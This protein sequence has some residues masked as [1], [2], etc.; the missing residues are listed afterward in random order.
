MAG[1]HRSHP[2]SDSGASRRR[3]LAHACQ[4]ITTSCMLK[5]AM[6]SRMGIKKRPPTS[7]KQWVTC[8]SPWVPSPDWVAFFITSLWGEP[9]MCTPSGNT[10]RF[11]PLSL[12]KL[13]TASAPEPTACSTRYMKP[14]CLGGSRTAQSSKS[15]AP[16]SNKSAALL[17]GLF[18]F[19][20]SMSNGLDT[21]TLSSSA[22]AT[23][24][25]KLQG[26]SLMKRKKSFV[27]AVTSSKF[28]QGTAA[29]FCT[30]A[31]VCSAPSAAAAMA[32]TTKAPAP[33]LGSMMLTPRASWMAS[34]RVGGSGTVASAVTSTV[35]CCAACAAPEPKTAVYTD[36][37]T[38]LR[39]DQ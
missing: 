39:C 36:D 1:E 16:P 17:T 33:S 6:D 11:G 5:K 15:S 28:D 22:M 10:R 14:S 7:T 9:E 3:T 35:G 29:H 18:S 8:L 31:I 2:R 4:S 26:Y 21:S 19:T 20:H 12:K 23:L 34:S 37:Q 32:A 24:Y 25:R 38:A 30:S 13:I 27:P